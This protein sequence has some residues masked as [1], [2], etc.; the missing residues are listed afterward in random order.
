VHTHAVIDSGSDFNIMHEK[1]AEKA[2]LTMITKP[3]LRQ[4]YT[5]GGH[6]I[7]TGVHKIVQVLAKIGNHEEKITLS[8]AD[9]GNDTMLLGHSLS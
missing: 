9:L 2:G 4:A 3:G 6:K 5:I 8:L 7:G 1:L